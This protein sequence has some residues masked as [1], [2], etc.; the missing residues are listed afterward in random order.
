MQVIEREEKLYTAEE[1]AEYLRVS[2]STVLRLIG[3]GKIIPFGKVG[4]SYRFTRQGLDASI[5]IPV[6]Q[7]PEQGEE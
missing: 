7:E 4:R 5:Q 1:A 6:D 2:Y 3:E